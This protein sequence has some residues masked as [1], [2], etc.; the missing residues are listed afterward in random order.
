MVLT[1]QLENNNINDK[2]ITLDN[3]VKNKIIELG[4]IFYNDG[5]QHINLWNNDEWNKKISLLNQEILEYKLEKDALISKFNGEKKELYNELNESFKIKYDNELNDLTQK[6]NELNQKYIELHDSLTV[7]HQAELKEQAIYNDNKCSKLQDK[8]DDIHKE[9]VSKFDKE[10]EKTII[11]TQNSAIK[12]QDG[13]EQL[14]KTLNLLFPTAE[15]EDTHNIPGRGDFI[16]KEEKIVL[17]IETKKYGKNVQKS[18]IDKFYRDIDSES[19]NDTNCGILISLNTG[20]CNKK[21]FEFEVRNKKPILFIHKLNENINNLKLALQLFKL[22][23]TQ[24]TIDLT[25]KE[26]ICSLKNISST[27]KRNF[28]KQKNKLDKFHNEQIE[29]LVQQQ[30]SVAEI[31]NILHVK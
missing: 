14:Y 17:F 10:R 13:E 11:K 7:K 1:V 30:N 25:C 27:I 18:E 15:I 2:F 12:G 29:L 22:I 23:L 5:K 28:S 8:I 9:Y 24:T 19:N 3:D 6:K 16:L 20:I 31:F 21:D 4:Y 26:T